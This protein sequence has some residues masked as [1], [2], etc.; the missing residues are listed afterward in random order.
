MFTSVGMPD[1]LSVVFADVPAATRFVAARPAGSEVIGA[2]ER[3]VVQPGSEAV[4]RLR[5][6]A[7]DALGVRP[8]LPAATPTGR[9]PHYCYL[10]RPAPTA[11]WRARCA[12]CR[13]AML[14]ADHGEAFGEA[15]S[16]AMR[17]RLHAAAALGAPVLHIPGRAPS[18]IREATT[19]TTSRPRSWRHS[20]VTLSPA[21]GIGRSLF[22]GAP[23][24]MRFA[25]NLNECRRLGHVRHRGAVHPRELAI[26]DAQ[27]AAG[28]DSDAGGLAPL[29]PGTRAPGAAARRAA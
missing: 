22:D 12:R 11:W 4:L 19:I 3:F 13:C 27:G 7:L 28:P 6:P 21:D 15:A 1:I 9:T 14:T 5:P 29:R 24:P 8:R 17:L 2:L 16:L 25:C 26:R 23:D 18:V 10:R 20:A